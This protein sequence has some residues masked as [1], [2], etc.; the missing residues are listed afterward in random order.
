METFYV[1]GGALAIWALLIAFL[2]ITRKTFPG[3]ATAERAIGGISALLVLGAIGAALVG[4]ANES[5][6]EHGDREAG[7]PSPGLSR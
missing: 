5:A 6:D 2:G 1:V 7:E 4:S 3:S